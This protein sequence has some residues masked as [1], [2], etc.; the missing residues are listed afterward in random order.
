MAEG[1]SYLKRDILRVAMPKT[2]SESPYVGGFNSPSMVGNSLP[3]AA[4]RAVEAGAQV[5]L[6]SVVMPVFN[7]KPEYLREAVSSVLRQTLKKFELLVVL[8]RN[9]KIHIG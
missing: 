8:P 7:T 2:C 5:P 3:G 4:S 9:I 6:V 1:V